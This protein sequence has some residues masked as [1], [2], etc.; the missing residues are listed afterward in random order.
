MEKSEGDQVSIRFTVTAGHNCDPSLWLSCDQSSKGLPLV[1][2]AFDTS[3]LALF[4]LEPVRWSGPRTAS[5]YHHVMSSMT[6]AL[7]L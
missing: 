1:A 4:A 5:L 6:H 3:I 7:G 2:P